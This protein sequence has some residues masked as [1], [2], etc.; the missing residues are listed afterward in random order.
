MDEDISPTCSRATTP[1]SDEMDKAQLPLSTDTI[2]ELSN[3]F[4]QH[5]LDPYAPETDGSTLSPP[6]LDIEPPT[7]PLR[8]ARRRSPSLLVWQ[9]RQSM[10]RRQR[11]PAHLSQISRVVEGLSR[12]VNPCYNATHPSSQ[13][14]SP[15][16][17]TSNPSSF[18][19]LESTPSLSGSEDSGC[20][21][22][23][24]SRR[25]IANKIS[26]ET[27]RG[28]TV[29]ALERRQQK[30]VLKKVRMRKSLMKIRPA[31]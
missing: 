22:D 9:Q 23:F 7:L 10:S 20:D 4:Q 15:V 2:V 14:R 31:T 1:V 26:K 28:A 24:S 25:L 29:D 18:S 19:S 6:A 8:A 16:S 12:D 30:L 3:R 17:P 27:R 21:H 13:Q 11:T 5:R